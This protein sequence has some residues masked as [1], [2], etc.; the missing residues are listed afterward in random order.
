M[1]KKKSVKQMKAK[2]IVAQLPSEWFYKYLQKYEKQM[3]ENDRVG[4]CIMIG[5]TT[6]LESKS[7]LS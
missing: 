2:S 4:F 7:G 3:S 1:A 6:V 5:K